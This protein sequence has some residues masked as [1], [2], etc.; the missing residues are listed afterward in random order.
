MTRRARAVLRALAIGCVASFGLLWPGAAHAGEDGFIADF[1]LVLGGGQNTLR[2]G[3]SGG[4]GNSYTV[5]AESHITT[6]YGQYLVGYHELAMHLGG[7]DNGLD[8]RYREKLLLGVS[9]PDSAV[10]QPYLRVGMGGE[11]RSN[12]LAL[13]THLD[14]PEAQ[15]GIAII[16]L[17][18]VSL[19]AGLDGAI[20][21]VGRY[22][23]GN[24]LRRELNGAPSGG[25][26]AQLHVW[27]LLARVDYLTYSQSHDTPAPEELRAR[28]CGLFPVFK[29][30][31]AAGFALCF[32]GTFMHGVGLGSD[33]SSADV[34]S[35]YAGVS[36]GI[37]FAASKGGAAERRGRS[38]PKP[39]PAPPEPEVQTEV[40]SPV[41][42]PPPPPREAPS[43][44]IAADTF[45]ADE[46]SQL[47]RSALAQLD[48]SA[49]MQQ[50]RNGASPLVVVLPF[51]STLVAPLSSAVENA[52]RAEVERFLP[53][54]SIKLIEPR[55]TDRA[56]AS[57]GRITLDAA[58]TLAIGRTLQA[59]YVITGNLVAGGS[60][61][62]GGVSLDVR[63]VD[64]KTG[65]VV[66]QDTERSTKTVPR[67]PEP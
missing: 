60:E 47:T 48:S 31:I 15:V 32:D 62:P 25:G 28:A 64:V 61:N 41:P 44:P 22:N 37:G 20:T 16:A 38:D 26:Y 67:T 4:I 55:A 2:G 13:H 7:G 65:K 43:A 49:L 8:G 36:F 30:G 29:D 45:D 57:R 54:H 39:R 34:R 53:A 58:D 23:T 35:S 42:P 52:P 50:W 6:W 5:A 17:P 19:D 14:L 21:L 33:G 66:W 51:T 63:V 46:A 18:G 11:Y 9:F 40:P 27:P 59:R 24:E 12:D 3:V 56:I 10:I 1:G